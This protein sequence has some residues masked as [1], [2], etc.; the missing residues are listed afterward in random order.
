MKNKLIVILGPTASG[1]TKLAVKLARVFKG[2][3]VS[4]DSRQVY[5]GLD[6]GTGKDLKDY[7]AIPYHL[8]DVANPKKRFSLSRYQTLAYRAIDDILKRGKTPFLVGGSGLYLQSI[9][10]GYQLTKVKPNLKLRNQLSKKSIKQLQGLAKNYKIKLNQSDFNNKRRL[11]RAIE[12]KKARNQK[13]KKSNPK[14]NCLLLGIKYPR[15]ILNKRIDQRLKERLQKQGLI[16]EVK[17][18]KKQGLSWK[19]LDDFGLEYRFIGQYLQG[20]LTYE[21]MFNKL[22]IAI[23]QFAKRQ[24]TW[25]KRDRAIIWLDNKKQVKKLIKNFLRL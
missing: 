25:F 12:I 5:Q 17:K 14:Y 21:E 16:Q 11:I 20:K 23:H 4:A 15:E 24:I 18:L 7:C 6:I 1:K 13:S 2:E 10:D 9:I 22:A 3:I 8:I 19:K